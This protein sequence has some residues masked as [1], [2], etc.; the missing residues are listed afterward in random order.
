VQTDPGFTTGKEAS[1]QAVSNLVL[2]ANDTKAIV[3]PRGT[4]YQDSQINPVAEFEVPYYSDI[5]FSPGKQ[6]DY[7]TSNSVYQDGYN[8]FAQTYADKRSTCDFH[9]AAGEDFQVYFFTGLPKMHFEFSPP[10]P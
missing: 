2:Q 9:V 6:V 3:G 4:L 10:L 8:W 7:S 5:R 1:Y